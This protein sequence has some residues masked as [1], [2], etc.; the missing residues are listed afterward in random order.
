MVPVKSIID[1]IINWTAFAK[2]INANSVSIA[3]NKGRQIHLY[4]N[5][6][7]LKEVS[8]IKKLGVRVNFGLVEEKEDVEWLVRHGIHEIWTDDVPK[9]KKNL[10]ELGL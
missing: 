6:F 10:Q 2:E 8:A 9:V 7:L 5:P 3:T 4:N 1:P